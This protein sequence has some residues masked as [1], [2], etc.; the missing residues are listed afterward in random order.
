MKCAVHKTCNHIRRRETW[1][2]GGLH[3]NSTG[4]C[5]FNVGEDFETDPSGLIRDDSVE[6]GYGRSCICTLKILL[7]I[8]FKFLLWSFGFATWS[9]CGIIWCTG[10]VFSTGEK[11]YT[12]TKGRNRILIF[13]FF[14]DD[15]FCSEPAVNYNIVLKKWT[16]L[17][18]DFVVP[19]L[20]PQLSMLSLS[21][22]SNMPSPF[23][24]HWQN[25]S[26]S[27]WTLQCKSS[28]WAPLIRQ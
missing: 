15:E 27:Q 13:F 24:P 26:L 19:A 14:L 6:G 28:L 1:Y 7:E 2:W 23:S 8:N 10:C 3:G 25:E 20:C 9:F 21:W 17:C 18:R 12:K 5:E 16:F 22:V 11:I 4:D